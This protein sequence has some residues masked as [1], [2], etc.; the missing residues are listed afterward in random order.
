MELWRLIRPHQRN[1]VVLVTVVIRCASQLS[2]WPDFLD[3]SDSKKAFLAFSQMPCGRSSRHLV[4]SEVGIRYKR[5][6]EGRSA[7]ER[8]TSRN[9]TGDRFQS[10]LKIGRFTQADLFGHL[11]ISGGFVPTF[12]G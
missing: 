6:L 1:M 3:C 8:C 12:A 10:V 5:D 2:L 7:V 9:G 11:G 4:L